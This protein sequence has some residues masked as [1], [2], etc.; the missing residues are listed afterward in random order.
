L[1]DEKED[2]PR[3]NGKNFQ[4]TRKKQPPGQGGGKQKGLIETKEGIF[5]PGRRG[6]VFLVKANPKTKLK[7]G[8]GEMALSHRRE[9]V[10]G[11]RSMV[12]SQQHLAG[13]GKKKLPRKTRTMG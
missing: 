6:T 3:A 11:T 1:D 10:Q 13:Q 12:D 4:E 5:R 9:E 8:F 7:N 2:G